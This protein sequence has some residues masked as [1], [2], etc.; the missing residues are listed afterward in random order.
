MSLC[1]RLRFPWED[2]QSEWPNLGSHT[3]ALAEWQPLVES[4]EMGVGSCPKEIWDALTKR[5]RKG[6]WAGKTNIS[7][8]SVYNKRNKL[9][10][11]VVR[12][13]SLD[14][15]QTDWMSTRW[16]GCKRIYHLMRFGLYH[17]TIPLKPEILCF[18]LWGGKLGP[19]FYSQHT[20]QMLLFR[21]Q[22]ES[23]SVF[24]RPLYLISLLSCLFR[25]IFLALLMLLIWQ[26]WGL[27]ENIKEICLWGQP[28]EHL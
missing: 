6:C 26:F 14:V 8:T 22:P 5:R 3:H 25:S 18:Y 19:H 23:N 16:Q 2:R 9:S 13:P 21:S 10:Q 24:S 4:L 11:K 1:A 17:L 7:I 12:S 27:K 28:S 15:F 20:F